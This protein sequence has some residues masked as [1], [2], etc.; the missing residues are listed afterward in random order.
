MVL[1]R[2]RELSRKHH[3]DNLS[4]GSHQAQMEIE[5]ARREALSELNAFEEAAGV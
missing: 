2:F 3:P 4:T 1:D 5:R